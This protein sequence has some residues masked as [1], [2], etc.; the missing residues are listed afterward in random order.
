MSVL[1]TRGS[2]YPGSLTVPPAARGSCATSS[3]RSAHPRTAVGEVFSVRLPAPGWRLR[4]RWCGK[5]PAVRRRASV[6]VRPARQGVA[7]R[8]AGA[9]GRRTG[10]L[11]PGCDAIDLSG[12]RCVRGAR[13]LAGRLG[14][15]PVP[16]D[17]GTR[18]PVRTGAVGARRA[19]RRPG[20]RRPTGLPHNVR[21]VPARLPA[22]TDMRSSGTTTGGGRSRHRRSRPAGSP[23]AEGSATCRAQRCGAAWSW[24]GIAGR[25][26]TERRSGRA[27]TGSGQPSTRARRA[28]SQSARRTT[29]GSTGSTAPAPQG[30]RSSAR[31][32]AG[33]STASAGSPAD[34]KR[35]V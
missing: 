23:V 32:A 21:V 20:L 16:R 13:V 25:R 34:D 15:P 6:A 12:G 26:Q 3:L 1:R 14:R 33:C 22:W 7:G 30:V 11:C 19:L 9:A 5:C 29:R 27:R 4:G 2:T 24:V 8:A 10:C 18:D 31:Q 28:G 35:T 17:D